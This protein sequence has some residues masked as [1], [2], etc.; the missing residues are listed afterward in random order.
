MDVFIM[1]AAHAIGDYP[2]QG[3]YLATTK[4]QNFWH[5]FMHSVIYTACIMV[6]FFFVTTHFMLA[7]VV[8]LGVLMSHVVID[9]LKSHGKIGYVTDQTLHL[10]VLAGILLLG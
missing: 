6:G 9:Y 5:L 1:L 3:E 8:C 7:G 10:L 2:M 4:G